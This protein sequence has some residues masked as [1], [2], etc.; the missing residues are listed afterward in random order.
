MDEDLREVSA[1]R[2]MELVESQRKWRENEC[3]NMIA[4]EN[5]MSE[6]AKKAYCSEFMH[7]YAEGEPYKRYYNGTKYIDALEV[8]ATD[9]F[10]ELLSAGFVDLRAISGTVA[11]FAALSSLTKP[12]DTIISVSTPAGG[13]ISHNKAGAPTALGLEV[14]NYVWDNEEMNIDVDASRK[15]IEERKPKVFILGGSLFLFPHPVREI[16][17]MAEQVE[18]KVMY[19]AAHVLGLIVGGEFQ[20]PFKEGADILTSSTH[21]TFPG[22]QGG[23]VASDD[24]SL[25][26]ILKRGVFPRLTSNHHL[27]R[28]PALAITALEM[29]RKGKEY[30]KQ[31]IKNAKTLGE[32]MHAL[33]LPVIGEHL[34]F[35]ESHQIALDM[36]KIN[37]R[38]SEVANKLEEGN[39]IVNK[40]L[41][42]WDDIKKV[43]D[44][45]GIRIGVQELTKRGM[46][47]EEMKKIAHFFKRIILDGEDPKKVKV[48][49]LELAKEFSSSDFFYL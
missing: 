29:K 7:R 26:S 43:S 9:L 11:N 22:P 44:P 1:D 8:I 24:E 45:S 37:K 3:L 48:D 17:E 47:E 27:H 46:K 19:D 49:V 21:K 15:I 16:K 33:G 34:G 18:G 10:K 31:V 25:A 36:S 14:V 20:Q 30:A 4:S 5:I 40:N 12:G 32:E 2:I 13:H 42:P 6:K 23:L 35:T 28:I 41:L 38:A 39:I